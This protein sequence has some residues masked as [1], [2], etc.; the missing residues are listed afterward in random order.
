[1]RLENGWKPRFKQSSSASH[2]AGGSGQQAERRRGRAAGNP[3][4]HTRPYAAHRS[5]SP[6]IGRDAWTRPRTQHP[7]HATGASRVR[8]EDAVPRPRAPRG[9]R[10]GLFCPITLRSRWTRRNEESAGQRNC[11]VP[12]DLLIGKLSSSLSAPK[13]RGWMDK[14]AGRRAGRGRG[15]SGSNFCP[16]FAQV[17]L[18]TALGVDSRGSDGRLRDLS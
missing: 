8:G 17:G 16:T 5:G 3:K 7:T 1:M 10:C 14:G 13:P 11:G 12:A 6:R 4:V 15:G 9:R 2:E 18:E